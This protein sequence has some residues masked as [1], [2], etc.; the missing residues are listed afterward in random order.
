MATQIQLRQDTQAAWDSATVTPAQGEVCLVYDTSDTDK[1]IGLKIGDGTTEWELIPFH[2]P[3]LSGIPNILEEDTSTANQP[4]G[5][6][7]SANDVTTFLLKG[8]SGQDAAV[9]GIEEAGAGTDLVLSIDKTGDIT[10][11]AGVNVSGGYD[12][13]ND[14]YGITIDTNGNVQT[15][16]GIES[17]DYDADCTTGGVLLSTDVPVS[18]DGTEPKYGKLSI[19]AMSTTDDTDNV[20]EVR[21]NDEEVFVVDADG[22]IDKVKNIDST[23]AITTTGL[24]TCAGITNSDAVI[25]AGTQKVTNV[26]DPTAGSQEAATANYVETVVSQNGW[27]LLGHQSLDGVA[28]GTVYLAI[29]DAG[30]RED[31]ADVYSGFR[32]VFSN[33]N[34][35]A[36]PYS[37]FSISFNCV[38]GGAATVV[39]TSSLQRAD[40][41]DSE[42]DLLVEIDCTQN[43]ADG[44]YLIKVLEKRY[45]L[46]IT[47]S[48]DDL[49]KNGTFIKNFSFTGPGSVSQAVGGEVTLY[50]LR[51]ATS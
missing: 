30:S 37:G 31:F 15:N 36:H 24:V 10:A 28:F 26:T 11:S 40:L 38:R 16:T 25:D 17:G 14:A 45:G 22:D 32:M 7:G 3:V 27:E 2:V 34:A 8:L 51:H 42:T 44:V 43:H 9:F 4:I 41:T 35:R 20:I 23:G 1:L 47:S 12:A 29:D 21:N 49:A 46:A 39:H 33:T 13:T 6:T 50:G 48:I 5:G 19:S 18:P